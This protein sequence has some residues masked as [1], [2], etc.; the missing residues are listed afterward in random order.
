MKSMPRNRSY[1]LTDQVVIT[2]LGAVCSLGNSVREISLGLSSGKSGISE[3]TDFDA[4]GFGCGA[5]QVKDPPVIKTDIHPH[6]A[7]TM[8]KHLSL[9]V[10]STGQAMGDAG[11]EP[12]RFEPE[13][14]GFF[15]GM[16]TVDYH[17]E[18]L[19]PAVA[20]SLGQ[21]GDLDY[22]RFF[23]AGYREIYPLWPL[24]MLNNV[25]FCQA[26]IHF[27]FRGE[28]AV[29]TS[30]GD[31]GIKA[32][33]EAVKVLGEG[34]AKVALAGGV[35]EE[36]SPLSLAR[37]RLKGLIGPPESV[38]DDLTAHGT[39]TGVFLG[40]CGA[41]LVLEPLPGAV[42][43]GADVLAKVI[44]FGFS[45]HRDVKNS[46]ASSQA[47]CSAMEGALSRAGIGPG[48]I[49]VIMLGS[50]GRNEVEAVGQTF[51]S[52]GKS[53]VVVSTAKA[54]GETFAAGPIL[55]AAMGLKISDWSGLPRRYLHMPDRWRRF[56][57]DPLEIRSAPGERDQL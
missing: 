55:N 25:A 18:D 53:P 54:L 40:E 22:D 49:D 4:S 31:A 46:F 30:H 35:S 11:I 9:L 36:I 13:D 43:R 42:A 47:I 8:G 2:G 19:L 48:Q 33:A 29:F 17:L 3:I 7:K 32:V 38:T 24:G 34:K 10:I 41:M 27:G 39:A 23:S 56:A 50:S 20:K 51:G 16:G 1:P 12:G 57:H 5:A 28:N 45:C 14:M 44:G 21:S 26:A 6:L 52:V 37:A 15:A